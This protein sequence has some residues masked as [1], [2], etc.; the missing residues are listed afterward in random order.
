[1]PHLTVPTERRGD[2]FRDDCLIPATLDAEIAAGAAGGPAVGMILPD[3]STA[4]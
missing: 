2:P 3:A 1:M 4:A